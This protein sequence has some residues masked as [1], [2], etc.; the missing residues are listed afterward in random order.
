[1]KCGMTDMDG[2][3]LGDQCQWKED[4]DTCP[5]VDDYLFGM[6]DRKFKRGQP[7]QRKANNGK[8]PAY[9]FKGKICGDYINP[10]T[11]TIGYVV[12]NDFEPGLI[13]IFPEY[14]LEPIRALTNEG[15]P[16]ED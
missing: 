2:C 11:G 8:P 14:M 15:E 7:V 13:Q 9:L 5:A 6:G 1:M 10:Q 3:A 12:S 16:H 4:Q